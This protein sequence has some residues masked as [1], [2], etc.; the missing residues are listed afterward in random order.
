MP[1]ADAPG[2]KDK[3]AKKEKK[4]K[5]KK[6]KKEKKAKKK[7]R[8]ERSSSPDTDNS[9]GSPKPGNAVRA[10]GS[11]LAPHSTSCQFFD[12]LC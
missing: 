12:A 4:A 6:D 5:E 8:K 1:D 7:K 3:K 11:H 10:V 9:A 2:K